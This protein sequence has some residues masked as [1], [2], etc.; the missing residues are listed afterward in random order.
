VSYLGTGT[1]KDSTEKPLR[2]KGKTAPEELA[3]EERQK[4]NRRVKVYSSDLSTRDSEA[5][6]CKPDCWTT[7]PKTTNHQSPLTHCTDS[8]NS[9]IQSFFFSTSRGFDPSAGPTI[10]SFSI[11]S[12]SRA[13]R[14]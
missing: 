14:P 4:G 2:G 9:F 13:A 11:R 5:G 3:T 1:T 10:P 8:S 12:I 6:I 7:A